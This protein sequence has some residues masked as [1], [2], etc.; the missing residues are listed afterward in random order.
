M[1]SQ[2]SRRFSYQTVFVQLLR[3]SPIRSNA[4]LIGLKIEISALAQFRHRLK[5]SVYD[6]FYKIMHVH[7]FCTISSQIIV[8]VHNFVTD[9]FLQNCADVNV[10]FPTQ[11]EHFT[12]LCKR[13]VLSQIFVQAHS[14]VTGFLC[15]A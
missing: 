3:P 2:N 5:Y 6:L 12:L 11:F 15:I 8:H 10:C 13:T 9:Y 7:M 14:C 1:C 4:G